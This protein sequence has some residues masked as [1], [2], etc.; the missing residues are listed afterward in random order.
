MQQEVNEPTATIVISTIPTGDY[1]VKI[2]GK[3]AMQVGKFVK[4]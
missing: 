2:I 4:Q 3:K 1:V